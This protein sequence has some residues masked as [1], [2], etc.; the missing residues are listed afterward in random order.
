M[1][2]EILIPK[3]FAEIK[4]APEKIGAYTDLFSLSMTEG[5]HRE[6]RE[7]RERW[8]NRERRKRLINC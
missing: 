4:K 6:N 5:L 2:N 1:N 8:E 7:M 3:I